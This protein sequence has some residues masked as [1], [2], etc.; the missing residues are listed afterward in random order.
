MKWKMLIAGLFVLVGMG[1]MAFPAA[2][3]NS[4]TINGVVYT[5]ANQCNVTISNGRYTVTD[6]CGGR[7]TLSFPPRGGGS[8]EEP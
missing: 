8:Q 7:V 2:A 4:V 5:C 1:L 6:C 3:S